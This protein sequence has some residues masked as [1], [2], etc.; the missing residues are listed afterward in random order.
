LYKSIKGK[1]KFDRI[2]ADVPCSG[3]GTF[4]K[5]P[6]LWRLFRPRI[7]LELHLI[8]LQIAKAS[9]LMLKAGGRMIYSTC[10][11]NP[12]EDEAVVAALLLYCGGRLKLV[13]VEKEGLLPGL[14]KRAGIST[15]TCDDEV[16]TIGEESDDARQASKA[17]LSQFA[18]SMFP[19]QE[20]V[21]VQLH[22]DRCIRLLPHDQDTGGFFVAVLEMASATDTVVPYFIPTPIGPLPTMQDGDDEE[23]VKIKKEREGISEKK[24]LETFKQLGFNAKSRQKEKERMKNKSSKGNKE[25]IK[26]DSTACTMYESLGSSFDI[27]KEK[28]NLDDKDLFSG[29]SELSDTSDVPR[30][31]STTAA[32]CLV[33]ATESTIPEV[34]VE[35]GKIGDDENVEL[36][37]AEEERIRR[38][39]LQQKSRDSNGIFG[40][41]STGWLKVEAEE[42]RDI[43]EGPY[44]MVQLVSQC[45]E[46]ALRIWARSDMVIQAGVTVC[47]YQESNE[48]WKVESDGAR[49]LLPHV[50]EKS[51]ILLSPADFS[52][53][54]R[55]GVEKEESVIMYKN[56]S[57]EDI[58]EEGELSVGVEI[59][60]ADGNIVPVDDGEDNDDGMEVLSTQGRVELWKECERRLELLD[61]E[62]TSS[63]IFSLIVSL[64]NPI[65]NGGGSNSKTSLQS[66]A[67]AV[68]SGSAQTKRRLSKA[69]RKSQK[70]NL[71]ETSADALSKKSG[72]VLLDD[73]S[74]LDDSDGMLE[75]ERGMVIVISVSYK[76][77]GDSYEGIRL[78][79]ATAA[80]VCESYGTAISSLKL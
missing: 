22:L 80:D 45:V 11:I 4:R 7:S 14:K 6:H 3:D 1:F 74:Q 54:L 64:K 69:E 31:I 13:D 10:S 67:S 71:K 15:W 72:S 42:E 29:L 8:Q 65:N 41:K 2:V 78:E 53:F 35:G 59:E 27:I 61:V 50:D 47:Q 76:I 21:A 9:A 18:L 17:K 19:P 23:K 37:K 79:V 39:K 38:K 75:L 24:T 30:N 46:D 70:S 12:L 36:S 68:E 32:C 43:V 26:L 5:F 51:L 20:E 49:A 66:L 62:D 77:V 48:L 33:I 63:Q 58:D 28:L 60:E 73:S 25:K 52:F 44:K 56:Q 40:S 16:F 34:S 55:Q 57:E